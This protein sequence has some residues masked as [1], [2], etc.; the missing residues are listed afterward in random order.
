[1]TAGTG[2]ESREGGGG[3]GTGGRRRPGDI[4]G[5]GSLGDPP[6]LQ[7]PNQSLG[8][9][10]L[11]H[12]ESPAHIIIQP[13]Q[14]RL[15]EPAHSY[16]GREEESKGE[17]GTSRVFSPLTGSPTGPDPFG[18]RVLPPQVNGREGD[19][20][21]MFDLSRLAPPQGSATP[22]MCRTPEAFL[23][24]TG[25]SL[26]NLDALIPPTPPSRTHNNPFLLGLTAPSPTNPFHCDQPR[27]TLNQML[28]PCS[29]S[30]LP[31]HTLPYSPPPSPTPL[32]PS[33]PLPLPHS[34]P[35][36]LLPTP[37]STGLP[38]HPL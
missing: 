5:A 36:S 16:S 12:L 2:E 6:L 10:T 7:Q 29:T 30:P 3:G 8:S 14:S 37:P 24:P 15:A 26:V 34:P 18:E 25:A 28:R 21:E 17:E 35:P 13:C 31:P 23:G 20:P 9:V 22:R 1:M 4:D 11:S 19:S 27:L 32:Q 33:L 38:R